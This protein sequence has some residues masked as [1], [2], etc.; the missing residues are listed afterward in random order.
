MTDVPPRL[1]L[2]PILFTLNLSSACDVLGTGPTVAT[3]ML[4]LNR[5]SVPRGG[6]LKMTYRFTASP[7]ITTV[8]EPYRVF[9]H[10]LDADGK[11]I[12]TDDHDPPVA[13][14]DWRPGETVT[15]ERRTF[16]PMYPPPA[17]GEASIAL[18]LYSPVTGDRLALAGVQSTRNAYVVATIE[19]V[20]RHE[21]S[22]L[23]FQDGW[24]PPEVGGA[25][26]WWQWTSGEATIEFR[27]PRQDATLSFWLD[28]R[29]GPVE[30]PQRVNL[31][32][33]NRI[34]DSFLLEAS[35]ATF[36]ST[37]VS[38]DDFGDDDVTELTLHADQTFTPAE[39]P[40]SDNAD[41]RQLGVRVFHAYLET[42]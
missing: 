19:V 37:T 3:P 16:I 13:T 40:G 6:P 4:S 9:V 42:R 15:Y 18:G 29:P 17:L 41:R 30:S 32:I 14:T 22:V 12:F 21:N 39:L 33:E 27:N 20:P 10:F 35:G 31:I 5:S 24:Y 7:E 25:S 36:H 28:G 34:I 38:A 11:I 2:L 1:W 23:T 8:T 26:E